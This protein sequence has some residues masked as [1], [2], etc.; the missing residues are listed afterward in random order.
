MELRGALNF[1]ILVCPDWSPARKALSSWQSIGLSC[2]SPS[3]LLSWFRS[4]DDI[5]GASPLIWSPPGSYQALLTI[6]P[7]LSQAC[8]LATSC[9]EC[10]AQVTGWRARYDTIVW[11]ATHAALRARHQFTSD[12][13]LKHALGLAKVLLL[14]GLLPRPL[15]NT[16][17]ILAFRRM[18][19]YQ[20]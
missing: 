9:T 6:P 20:N 18:F 4:A 3:G 15:I 13:G 5:V 16:T 7:A 1:K 17:L 12:L 2:K 8:S 10:A 14:A 19:V 11:N